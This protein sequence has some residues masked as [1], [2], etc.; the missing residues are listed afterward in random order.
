MTYQQRDTAAAATDIGTEIYALAAEL[1][2]ICRSL[3]GPG[4]RQTLAIIDREIGLELTEVPTGTPALD[5]TVPREWSVRE[6][7]IRDPS[8]RTVLDFADCNL[9]VL[10][11]SVS[12][13][14]RTAITRIRKA[15]ARRAVAW[16]MSP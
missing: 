14:R 3:A 5:W 12:V 15:R 10:N 16:P 11:Y 8:G 4:V 6:A 13:R 7:W 1:Y 2:P 9:H